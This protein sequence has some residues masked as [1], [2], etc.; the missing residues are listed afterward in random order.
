VLRDTREPLTRP[1]PQLAPA[2]RRW[3]PAP[4]GLSTAALALLSG[5]RS[6]SGAVTPVPPRCSAGGG[7]HPRTSRV[8]F[9]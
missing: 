5:L 3:L 9:R 1:L 4:I 2:G 6:R 8:A 7:R